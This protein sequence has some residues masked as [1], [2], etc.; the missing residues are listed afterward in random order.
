MKS[1]KANV[2]ELVDTAHAWLREHPGAQS[3]QLAPAAGAAPSAIGAWE[4]R[5]GV[6]L[7]EDLRDFYLLNDGLQLKWNVV[8]HGREVVPL[9]CLAVNA[10]ERLTPAPE[11]TLRNERDELRAELPGGTASSVRA[12]ELDATCEAGRVLLLLGLD[13]GTRRGQV[14]FQDGSCALSRLATSFGE[15]LR[16]LVLHLGLPRWQYAYTEAGLDPTCRQWLRLMAPDRLAVPPA[17]K[18]H[19]NGADG[20]DGGGAPDGAYGFGVGWCGAADARDSLP[21]R[22]A[23][24]EVGPPSH[25][26][27][28][29]LLSLTTLQQQQCVAGHSV[30]RP[31]SAAGAPRS[32][33][34][35]LSG[36]GA[37]SRASSSTSTASSSSTAAASARPT[38]GRR[39][40]SASSRNGRARAQRGHEGPPAEE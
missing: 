7:P 18:A 31:S 26:D 24:V 20:D 40:S 6:L 30:S 8:A 38:G 35:L 11:R 1:E 29:R 16:L 32:A 39:G 3:V 27:T 13:L 21:V 10:L 36:G 33:V 12:F 25:A 2:A 9:G 17:T 15:Y 5:H 37:C 4:Q 19:P 22:T 28:L 34:A 23:W 14:W